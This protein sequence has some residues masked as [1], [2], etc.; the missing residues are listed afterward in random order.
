MWLVSVSMVSMS[1]FGSA[2]SAN[3]GFTRTFAG[4]EPLVSPKA[5]ALHLSL[6][7]DKDG[8][9]AVHPSPTFFYLF[10]GLDGTDE[11]LELPAQNV[12]HLKDWD[13]QAALDTLLS[14]EKIT[15]VHAKDMPLMFLSN[16]SAKDPDYAKRHPG[17]STVTLVAPTKYE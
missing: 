2:S 8:S 12:W 6:L 1:L 7:R 5:G 10:V 16:E 9:L 15:D 14:V 3:A 17:K 4:A 11:E 13:Q